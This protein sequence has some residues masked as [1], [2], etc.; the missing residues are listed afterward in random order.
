M[1]YGLADAGGLTSETDGLEDTTCQTKRLEPRHGRQCRTHKREF[2]CCWFTPRGRQKE[3]IIEVE[4]ENKER[5][6]IQPQSI[7]RWFRPMI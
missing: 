3:R 2:K 4:K 7:L 6:A 1:I 5:G